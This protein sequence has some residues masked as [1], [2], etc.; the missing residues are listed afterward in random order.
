MLNF[1]FTDIQ[2][3][4]IIFLVGIIF[5]F[6]NLY[7]FLFYKKQVYKKAYKKFYFKKI[8]KYVLDTD[9]LLIN[10]FNYKQGYKNGFSIDHLLFG[11]KYIYLIFDEYY[12]GFINGKIND[13]SWIYYPLNNKSKIIHNKI[14]DIKKEVNNFIE[15]TNLDNNLFKTIILFNNDCILQIDKYNNKELNKDTYLVN[16]SYVIKLIKNLENSN[17]NDI[18]QEQVIQT[19]NDL[20]KI[21]SKI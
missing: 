9:Y 17:I 7:L 15:L 20:Y 12:L 8:Y 11:K 6:I 19:C 13:N 10:N 14:N 1:L 4:Y 2:I 21:K 16:L 5:V 3:I 18:N